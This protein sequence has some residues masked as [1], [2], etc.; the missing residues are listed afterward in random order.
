M[1]IDNNVLLAS[2]MVSNILINE[3][4]FTFH[5][6]QIHCL[7]QVPAGFCRRHENRLVGLFQGDHRVPLFLGNS[8]LDFLWSPGMR[9]G[10]KLFS[11]NYFLIF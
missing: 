3:T 11:P 8:H 5:S 2:E 7:N 6:L 1:A 9:T 10:I 4:G